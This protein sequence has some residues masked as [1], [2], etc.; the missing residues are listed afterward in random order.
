[1]ECVSEKMELKYNAEEVSPRC[2]FCNKC[3]DELTLTDMETNSLYF[4]DRT[5]EYGELLF[6]VFQFR[7]STI[8]FACSPTE[9][10]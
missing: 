4:N 2:T 10:Y 8:K 7:V 6:E 1:M 5:I 3:E 9:M